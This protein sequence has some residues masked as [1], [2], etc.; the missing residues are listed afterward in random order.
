MPQ[1][2]SEDRPLLSGIARSSLSS[3]LSKPKPTK[4]GQSHAPNKPPPGSSSPSAEDSACLLRRPL[5]LS[6]DATVL[7]SPAHLAA[8]SPAIS[9]H[10]RHLPCHRSSIFATPRAAVRS[11]GSIGLLAQHLVRRRGCGLSVAL[12]MGLHVAPLRQRQG[13]ISSFVYRRPAV[14]KPRRWWL[15]CRPSG[16]CL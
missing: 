14:F 2:A 7:P 15:E 12:E 4:S 3:S 8:T 11:A 10:P 5:V 6:I 1:D 9:L 13:S 16:F